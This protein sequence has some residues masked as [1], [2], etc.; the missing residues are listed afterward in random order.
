MSEY[1]DL[2]DGLTQASE[3]SAPNA[4]S[5]EPKKK[6]AKRVSKPRRESPKQATL[7]AQPKLETP[8]EPAR[9]GMDRLLER[10]GRCPMYAPKGT[11]C[12]TC[13]KVHPL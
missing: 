6:Q 8:A 10:T 11:T 12:K 1:D 9:R 5:P 13:G 7:V 3:P 4:V 2:L